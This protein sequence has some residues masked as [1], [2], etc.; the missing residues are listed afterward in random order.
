MDIMDFGL[1]AQRLAETHVAACEEALWSDPQTEQESP[2]SA[3]YCGC[4]TCTVREVLYAAW[5]VME[6]YIAEGLNPRPTAPTE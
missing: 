2:A 4:L 6:A 5:V 1:A 3:P